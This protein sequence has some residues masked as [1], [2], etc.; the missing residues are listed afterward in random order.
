MAID[1][2]HKANGC[3][4]VIPGSHRWG[5]LS[6]KIPDMVVN[7]GFHGIQPP[8]PHTIDSLIEQQVY[9]ELDPGSA[10]FFHPFLVHGS[11][12][13]KTTSFRLAMTTHYASAECHFV[14]LRSHPMG[15]EANL[16]VAMDFVELSKDPKFKEM[17]HGASEEER[18]EIMSLGQILGWKGRSRLV[19]GEERGW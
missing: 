4:T 12:L 14:D 9:V 10:V 13:N 8:K 16:S 17:M 3:L 19:C 5:L 11:G 7:A 15:R 6:H 1:P 18:E 2:A